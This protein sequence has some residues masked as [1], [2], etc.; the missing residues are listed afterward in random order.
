MVQYSAGADK[1]ETPKFDPDD[2]ST[3]TD[4]DLELMRVTLT[5]MYAAFAND[6]RP[7]RNGAVRADADRDRPQTTE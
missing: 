7:T 5:G 2:A 4:E 6:Q 3:W 1:P